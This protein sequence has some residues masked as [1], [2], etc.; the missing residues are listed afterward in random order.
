MFCM[1]VHGVAKCC[2]HMSWASLCSILSYVGSP[3]HSIQC[4]CCLV[5][6]GSVLHAGRA[7]HIMR[8]VCQCIHGAGMVCCGHDVG[9]CLCI[10]QT[11]MGSWVLG[12][13]S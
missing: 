10:G 9:V 8:W 5:S 13:V 4:M 11:S 12:H 2:V 7:L 6:L 3:W 1:S